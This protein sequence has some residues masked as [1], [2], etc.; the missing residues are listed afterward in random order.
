MIDI[1]FN[2]ITLA[3]NHL[4]D[5]G[6]D[7]LRA[8]LDYWDSRIE[9][10]PGL[11]V[12]G[13]F[14]NEED[15][16][17]IRIT[18]ING[19]KLA[20]LSFTETTNGYHLPSDSELQIIYLSETARMQQ[21][22]SAAK[23]QADA[24]IVA[25]HWGVE[26]THTVSEGVQ[27]LAQ[28]LVEWGADVVIGNHPHTAQTMEYLT[29]SDGTQGFVFYSMGNFISAQTDNFNVVGELA[30][31]ELR[32]EL[33]TGQVYVEEIKVMPVITHY[34]D[35][36]FT[37][38]RLYPYYLYTEELANGHGLPYAPAGTAKR[39]NMDVV[40]AIVEANIPAQFR[41]LDAPAS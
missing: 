29:R 10:N 40:N 26:D 28:Q 39:F 38:L 33:E 37:N 4:L 25:A 23:E 2:C 5:K 15:M 32:L 6:A 8:A 18:E 3:N 7:G 12:T 13:A 17:N 36:S 20:V 21:Q 14:R 30:D 34:D 9:Q 35:G 31:F 22:I 24:V 1:G 11:L 19:M 16:Q 27:Y 41:W